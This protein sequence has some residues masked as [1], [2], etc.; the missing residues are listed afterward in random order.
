[1]EEVRL[2][3]A[4]ALHKR[5]KFWFLTDRCVICHTHLCPVFDL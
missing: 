4:N 2:I 3:D 5:I 1:M